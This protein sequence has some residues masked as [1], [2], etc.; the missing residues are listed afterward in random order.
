MDWQKTQ[1][2]D[3]VFVSDHR[4]HAVRH[5]DEGIG[6]LSGIKKCIHGRRVNAA[7]DFPVSQVD[8]GI[9]RHGVYRD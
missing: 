1:F 3:E 9:V 6:G 8:L 4:P 5:R 2:V 7:R